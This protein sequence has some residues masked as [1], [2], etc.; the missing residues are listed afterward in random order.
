VVC[1]FHGDRTASGS[2]YTGTDGRWRYR[3]HACDAAG[4]AADIIA[5]HTGRP[6]A[7]VLADQRGSPPPRSFATPEALAVT[8][9]R[10]QPEA[11]YRYQTA[12]GRDHLAVLRLPGKQFRQARWTA[13]GW[14][15]GGVG[16]PFPLYH[17]PAMAGDLSSVVV[18]TEGEKDADALSAL[19]ILAT[20]TP[21][22]ADAATCQMEKDGKPGKVDWS[23][24]TGRTVILW[25]DADE[26]GKRHMA[27]VARCLG[28]LQPIPAILTVRD[29]DRRG[30]KDA[31]DLIALHGEQAARDAIAHAVAQVPEP[32]VPRFDLRTFADTPT[33][34]IEWVM[35][36]L[37]AHGMVTLLG[38]KQ[39]LGKSYVLCD[40]AARIST[41]QP[42]PD[43]SITASSNVLMLVREDDPGA[44]LKARLQSAGADPSRVSWSTLA[45]AT[46]GAPLDLAKEC[47][48]VAEIIA[49][50][51][52]GVV[53]VDTFAA[54]ASTG[55]DA[56]A[57][58]DVR[59]VL[60][61]IVRAARDT[62]AAVIVT[63]HVRKSGVGEGD[64]M[65][66][67]AG[68]AQM[69]AGVRI[70][71]LLEPGQQEGERWLRVVK[72][73]IGPVNSTGWTFRFASSAVTVNTAIDLPPRLV[74]QVAGDVYR[75]ADTDRRLG[76][77]TIDPEALLNAVLAAVEKRPLT[78]K[79][80][81][82]RA[83]NKIRETMP[84]V[85]KVDI[86]AAVEDLVVDPPTCLEVGKGEKN[87]RLI[88]LPGTIPELP[89]DKA[90]RLAKPGMTVDEVT[91][92]YGCRRQVAAAILREIRQ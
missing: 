25:G 47:A 55:T 91:K 69:T 92:Q 83:W 8:L 6:L 18:V 34:T 9:H 21:M 19:G 87:A 70:A 82:H 78:V 15:S 2:L 11:V 5:R 54:F 53:I 56:N 13:D 84:K 46:T 74:W 27:R 10:Y 36:G 59:A 24:L 85:T 60:D 43:G 16:E 31:A 20:T 40:L 17:Q 61:P 12:D 1:A 14:Q 49:S 42:L 72:C 67:I 73:N 88:G 77:A 75:L 37:I 48:H 76:R 28:R 7:Q 66:V 79:D 45:D 35:P 89:E 29:E 80:A 68:S 41:G 4:D 50:R 33:T 65:D 23:Q 81:A 39:G 51:S 86:I 3:C 32:P 22:G 71:A 44:V 38:G 52:F 57:A 63:A 58:Q 26:P 30:T 62:G 90:R 64:P